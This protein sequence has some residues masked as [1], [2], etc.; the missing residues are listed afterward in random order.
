VRY[1]LWKLEIFTN[2]EISIKQVILVLVLQCFIS[3]GSHCEIFKSLKIHIKV[4][5]TKILDL[6]G[7]NVHR[8]MS[9]GPRN[10][11]N[12]LL[13]PWLL[14]LIL[15]PINPEVHTNL[16]GVMHS[17]V[18]YAFVSSKGLRLIKG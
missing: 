12:N 10:S 18:Q 15:K 11:N 2:L 1:I 8:Y 9:D 17:C 16:R 6:E 3:E 14:T 13:Y 4:L 7:F 5:Q